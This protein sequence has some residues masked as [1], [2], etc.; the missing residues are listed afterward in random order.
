MYVTLTLGLALA[1]SHWRAFNSFDLALPSHLTE[2]PPD[3]AAIDETKARKRAFFSYFKPLVDHINTTISMDRKLVLNLRAEFDGEGQLSEKQATALNNLADRYEVAATPE[4]SV[5]F[6][7]L[8]LR[9]N[10]VPVSLALAQAANESAWGTSRFAVKGNNY[11]G[12]WC[13]SAGCGLVPANR[14]AG[15]RHEVQVFDSPMASVR[16]YI[17]NINTFD[18]YSEF[19]QVRS[20]MAASGK[21]LSGLELATTLGKYSE[22][23]EDYIAEIQAMI[24]VNALESLSLAESEDTIKAL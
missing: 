21:P 20:A 19:R 16:A 23:G 18:A 17:H 10:Q 12:Q 3:F 15:A 1:L 6:A 11:F 14:N 22:R 4:K 2:A 8:L 9:V 7:Q 24:R 13:F 5:I